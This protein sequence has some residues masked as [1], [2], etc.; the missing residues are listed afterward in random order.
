M[1][2]PGRKIKRIPREKP[3]D[4][5]FERKIY[6]GGGEAGKILFVNTDGTL[7]DAIPSTL[8]SLAEENKAL[9][10]R[11]QSIVDKLMQDT[12]SNKETVKVV[13]TKNSILQKI[14]G[15]FA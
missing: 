15:L 8:D 10:I 11:L 6:S 13:A 12:H 5:K 4:F 3:A 1:E 14:K 9:S 2:Q 7:G